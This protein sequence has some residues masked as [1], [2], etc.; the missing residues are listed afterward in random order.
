MWVIIR[1]ME[2][3]EIRVLVTEKISG[4]ETD[5]S[6]ESS[7]YWFQCSGLISET[8]FLGHWNCSDMNYCILP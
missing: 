6:V 3:T 2:E 5:H 4:H 7:E 8:P 1:C